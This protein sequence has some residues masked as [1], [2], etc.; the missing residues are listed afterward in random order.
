M[1]V[2]WLDHGGVLLGSYVW[3]MCGVASER[4][5]ARRPYHVMRASLLK[6]PEARLPSSGGPQAGLLAGGVAM[7]MEALDRRSLLRLAPVFWSRATA[8][9]WRGVARGGG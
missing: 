8:W 6:R 4:F 1:S 2:R 5:E 7:Q 9:S 3:V